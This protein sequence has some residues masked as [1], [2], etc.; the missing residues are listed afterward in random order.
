MCSVGRD[1]IGEGQI[2]AP[3]HL[4]LEMQMVESH[5]VGAG[6]SSWVLSESS[7]SSALLNHLSKSWAISPTPEMGKE[8]NENVGEEMAKSVINPQA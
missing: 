6:C 8:N 2:G 4:E 7:K 5:Q 3:D 1:S